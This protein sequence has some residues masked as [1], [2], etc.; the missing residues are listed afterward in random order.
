MDENAVGFT[1]R[2]FLNVKLVL[3][4]AFPHAQ[5]L[6]EEDAYAFTPIS[7]LVNKPIIKQ[8]TITIST[9]SAGLGRRQEAGG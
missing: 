9:G 2:A 6:R 4:P 7:V 3:F 5:A 8:P 1:K